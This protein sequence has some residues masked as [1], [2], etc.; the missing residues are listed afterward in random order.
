MRDRFPELVDHLDA[1]RTVAIV[2]GEPPV[3][4]P[5]W[6]VVVDGVPVVRSA[7]GPDAAWY[8]RALDRGRTEFSLGDG[9]VAERDRAAALRDERVPVRVRYSPIDD[10]L[11]ERVD[12]AFEAKYGAHEP[13]STA[14]MLREPALSCTLVVEPAV[15]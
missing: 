1:T 9:R 11:R 13:E 2:T 4:T 8:R 6:A 15:E 14:I 12:A 3:A 10:P 7:Y 5:I